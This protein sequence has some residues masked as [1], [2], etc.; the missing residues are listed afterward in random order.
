MKD[1]RYWILLGVAL[2]I[3]CGSKETTA[4]QGNNGGSRADSGAFSSGS[5]GETGSSVGDASGS[6]YSDVAGSGFSTSGGAGSG[7]VADSAGA[8]GATGSGGKAGSGSGG[9]AGSGAVRVCGPSE[10]RSCFGKSPSWVEVSG[11]ANDADG[12]ELRGS[13]RVSSEFEFHK[14]TAR[15]GSCRF[16]T[17]EPSF[18]DPQC[19]SG[20]FCADG[21]CVTAPL[22]YELSPDTCDPPCASGQY[23][24]GARCAA[25]PGLID[26]GTLTLTGIVSSPVQVS[27]DKRPFFYSNNAQ[28]PN[29]GSLT[30]L[31][32]S[33]GTVG[34]FDLAVQSPLEAPEPLEDWS[35]L[36]ENRAPGQD[37]ILR[38]A[39]PD[40][41]TRISLYMTTGMGTHGGISPVEIECEGL[42]R[43]YLTLPGSYLDALYNIFYWSCGICGNNRL[44]RYRAIRTKVGSYEI[45]FQVAHFSGFGYR[46][47][48]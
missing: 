23:C 3:G 29:W 26:A 35:A 32:A 36:L 20:Q 10:D 33:G 14:E 42:D 24:R 9:K 17:Y 21:T 43:G 45:E 48:P 12:V 11:S 19:A 5:G 28:S 27:L 4:H 18:C 31:S 2:V 7:G 46:P 39:N 47:Q 15:S 30:K 16:L 25:A 8:S 22:I 40:E 1:V 13:F 34:P 41:S 44:S 38:W 37:V 6:G